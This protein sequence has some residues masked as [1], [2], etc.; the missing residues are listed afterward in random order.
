[1]TEKE[2]EAIAYCR[3]FV[4]WLDGLTGI[5]PLI[6]GGIGDTWH[7]AADM[8]MGIGDKVMDKPKK[9]TLEYYDY[10]EC[11]KWLA[12]EHGVVLASFWDWMSDG[13]GFQ[14]GSYETF[15]SRALEGME[16]PYAREG[17]K[18][19]LDEFGKTDPGNGEQSITL[20]IWW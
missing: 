19:L 9:Q 14:N 16:S 5:G 6:P 13:D 1:M 3:Q 10:N 17:L 2:H 12:Q 15:S 8:L 20:G 18:L 4:A 7:A 11:E